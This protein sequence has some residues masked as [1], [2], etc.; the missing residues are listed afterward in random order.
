M[1]FQSDKGWGHVY[2]AD[3]YRSSPRRNPI[4]DGS[5]ASI[6]GNYTNV[7]SSRVLRGGSWGAGSLVV[8]VANRTPNSPASTNGDYGFRCVRAVSP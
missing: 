1:Y 8:R 2:D 3:F 6:I 7:R 5:V 4:P